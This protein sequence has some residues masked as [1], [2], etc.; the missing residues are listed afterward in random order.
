MGRLSSGSFGASASILQPAGSARPQPGPA[1]SAPSRPSRAIGAPMHAPPGAERQGLPVPGS[2]VAS[3]KCINLTRRH[4]AVV[5]SHRS[6]RR[7]CTAR[8]G[9][10]RRSQCPPSVA[11]TAAAT[12]EALCVADSREPA[13]V[14]TLP[15]NRRLHCPGSGPMVTLAIT[16]T[17]STGSARP[18]CHNQRINLTRRRSGG[19]CSSQTARR[20]RAS[21]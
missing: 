15:G 12:R 21:R 13:L 10:Q 3:N 20:L 11:V 8:Y 18:G 16:G 19:R 17:C 1:Q 6:A 4:A 9:K 14:S 5:S 7:L 2:E